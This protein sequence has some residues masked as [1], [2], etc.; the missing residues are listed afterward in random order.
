MS[1]TSRFCFF[2][3]S[4]PPAA[5]WEH[6]NVWGTRGITEIISKKGPLCP[7]E[8][9]L[10]VLAVLPTWRL[11]FHNHQF[12]NV[13]WRARWALR[14]HLWF[15][16]VC[17]GSRV[18]PLWALTNSTCGG[19]SSFGWFL[20]SLFLLAY[21]RAPE[22]FVRRRPGEGRWRCQTEH[23][24][25]NSSLYALCFFKGKNPTLNT[26][27]AGFLTSNFWWLAS[28]ICGWYFLHFRR[29]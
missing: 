6:R 7:E 19:G 20:G 5:M 25:T 15:L 17:D 2:S 4:W 23:R 16:R 10:S 18:F 26:L 24:G 3:S 9:I 11:G 28:N 14:Y 12:P 29:C 8:S 1:C 13:P 21:R 27:S 22:C